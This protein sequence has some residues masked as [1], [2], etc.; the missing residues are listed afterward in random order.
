MG[1]ENSTSSRSNTIDGVLKKTS[2]AD[3]LDKALG[4]LG[5]HGF[6]NKGSHATSYTNNLETAK[7]TWWIEDA[8]SCHVSGTVV[9]HKESGETILFVEI[10]EHI[11][12]R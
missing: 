7:N 2:P 8:P 6:R 9:I 1:Q 3:V 5:Q 10:N 11:G 4:A 12:R